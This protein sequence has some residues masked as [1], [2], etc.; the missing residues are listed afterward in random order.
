MRLAMVRQKSG[1]L[2]STYLS[3]IQLDVGVDHIQVIG[4]D[5]VKVAQ[6][7]ACQQSRRKADQNQHAYALVRPATS[8]ECRELD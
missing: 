4:I 7:G 5:D 8:L 3:T 1:R 2:C 6:T